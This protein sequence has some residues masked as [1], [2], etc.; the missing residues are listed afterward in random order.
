MSVK[1][2][3]WICGGAVILAMGV[4]SG[5]LLIRKDVNKRYLTLYGNVDVRQVDMGFRVEGKVEKLFYEEGDLVKAGSLM[6]VLDKAP[7]DSRVVQAEA[8]VEAAAVRL[9]N[10]EILLNRRE[11]LI[12]IGGVSQEDLDTALTNRN[13]LKA[14]LLE[15]QANLQVAR[16]NYAF[17]EVFAP[18][19]GIILTRIRE[20][21]SVVLASEPVYTLSVISPVWIRAYVGEPNL[22]FVDYGMVAKVFT[23]TPGGKVY[24]AHVG[25][26][27]PVSEFTPKTV[28][29][30]EL[31]TDLV[32]RLRL[33]V[34][35][36]DWGLK[37]GMP[38]TV[39]IPL[40]KR[41][42]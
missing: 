8:T 2:F 21:G 13:Q 5:V 7:Y 23:D 31:R 37:Q 10:A 36:P 11:E 25:F 40:K 28:E 3:V 9:R 19:D 29:T 15:A 12:G 35:N 27:S 14:D 18:T 39:R 26:I 32:Y 38:V 41:K 1:K 30:M 4:Y 33:Y 17:T 24:R 6:A 42:A 22:G 20:P 16:D 34:D